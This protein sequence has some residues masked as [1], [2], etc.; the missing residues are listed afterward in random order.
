ME[1][2][3]PYVVGS[4]AFAFVG[5]KV[6]NYIY[7]DNSELLKKDNLEESYFE[8]ETIEKDGSESVKESI[9][10]IKKIKC[11]LCNNILPLNCFSKNQLKK[12]RTKIK[13]K[14]CTKLN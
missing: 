7:S 12:L 5:K 14:I 13:C 1:I 10:E 4:T 8:I 6:M 2:Y 9:E 3:V 11:N